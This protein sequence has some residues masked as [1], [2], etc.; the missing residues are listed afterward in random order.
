MD[1][2]NVGDSYEF[3]GIVHKVSGVKYT[4]D[5]KFILLLNVKLLND[6]EIFR[7]HL[8]IPVTKRTK[9]VL[10]DTNGNLKK[11]CIV[12]FSGRIE[13]Y[14]SANLDEKYSIKHLRNLKIIGENS[15][16]TK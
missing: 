11:D 15:N 13:L 7:D 10:I 12:Q 14:S 6:D 5:V 8:W 4:T 1:K 9:K 16:E 2:I 3:T